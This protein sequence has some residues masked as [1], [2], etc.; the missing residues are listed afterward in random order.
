M[1]T[2]KLDQD[3]DGKP[4]I[5][6]VDGSGEVQSVSPDNKLPVEATFSGS[7]T[8]GS[9]QVED[10][11]EDIINPAKEDGNLAAAASAAASGACSLQT[12]A[13][14]V[15]DGSMQVSGSFSAEIDA[16]RIKDG[17]C[18]IIDPATE[19]TLV[20]A[21]CSLQA[22]D[23]SI[24]A[25]AETVALE[26]GN[27]YS[28]ACSL[29]TLAENIP[30]GYA[31][32]TSV[33]A[34]ETEI[35]VL[36]DDL[37]ALMNAGSVRVTD[38]DGA[39][40]DTVAAIRGSIPVAKDSRINAIYNA[41][42]DSYVQADIEAGINGAVANGALYA[43]VPVADIA[44]VKKASTILISSGYVVE[45]SPTA[46]IPDRHFLGTDPGAVTW[47]EGG[48]NTNQYA[49]GMIFQTSVPAKVKGLRFYRHTQM[50]GTVVAGLFTESDAACI[51]QT[52][53]IDLGDPY[54]TPSGWQEIMFQEEISVQSGMCYTIVLGM[55]CAFYV[56]SYEDTTIYNDGSCQWQNAWLETIVRPARALM[57][58]DGP[59][60]PAYQ[61]AYPSGGELWPGFFNVDV[62]MEADAEY[63][64]K[65][66]W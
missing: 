45:V 44:Q 36:N 6:F 61:M 52:P 12:I 26:D 22:V 18:N 62:I 2:N 60:D 20:N 32:N 17:S 39:C 42:L 53:D 63:N 15:V 9:V 16:V 11:S 43:E 24:S 57:M 4:V 40:M 47:D 13:A 8:I 56:R 7:I 31:L 25:M 58:S 1:P 35:S 54:V 46:N 50:T 33:D 38:Y 49:L 41:A 10:S 51:I 48:P 27:L 23:A 14:A 3:S 28:A 66:F 55:H 34:V 37:T 65:V 59:Y 29:Q 30:A 19:E 5:G 21:V 64:V